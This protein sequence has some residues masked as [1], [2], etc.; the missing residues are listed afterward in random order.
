MFNL[1]FAFG[2]AKKQTL[3]VSTVFP[4][5]YYRLVE[6]IV[7][8]NDTFVWREGFPEKLTS[9]LTVLPLSKAILTHKIMRLY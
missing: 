2:N 8:M 7:G 6:L 9:V 5:E 3:K 1:C 4:Q